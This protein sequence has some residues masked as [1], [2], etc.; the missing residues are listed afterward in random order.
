MKPESHQDIFEE[1]LRKLVAAAAGDRDSGFQDRLS[2]A[3]GGEVRRRRSVVRHRL[4]LGGFAA[5]AALVVAVSLFMSTGNVAQV[6]QVHPIYGATELDGGGSVQKVLDDQQ[7]SPAQTIRTL[8][9]SRAEVRMSDGSRLV[10]S[11][12]T[13]LQARRE[14]RGVRVSLQSGAVDV[15]V[16]RQQGGRSFRVQT[17]GS[18][19]K[20]LGTA[21]EVRLASR[22]DGGGRTR[23]AVTSGTVELESGESSVLLPA[24]TE[25]VA[26]EGR[27]PERHLGSLELNELVSLLKRNEELA[28]QTNKEPGQPCIVHFKGGSTA[29]IWTLIRLSNFKRSSAGT[30]SLRLVCPASKAKVFT[31]D[32]QSVPATGQGRNLSIAASNLGVAADTDL[33]LELPEVSGVFQAQSGGTIA[34]HRPVNPR[35]VTLFQLHLPARANIG[36]IS[37]EPVDTTR[38]LDRQVI[39]IAANADRLQVWE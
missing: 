8:S 37:P 36:R 13:S 18:Q 7:I 29:A 22:P 21:F 23:V 31:L 39:T 2:R 5:A 4:F 17:P 38:K 3:V 12:R 34:F 9:G 28:R 20:A 10:L 24:N 1:N 32:G 11:P 30:Y 16:A 6:G 26:D 35:V 19:V 27:A 33:I 15:E 14:K 25:G